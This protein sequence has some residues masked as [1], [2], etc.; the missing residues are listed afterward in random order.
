MASERAGRGGGGPQTDL[1]R[2]EESLSSS[3]TARPSAQYKF[4]VFSTSLALLAT[5]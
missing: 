2:M 5:T 4:F 3:L 1:R